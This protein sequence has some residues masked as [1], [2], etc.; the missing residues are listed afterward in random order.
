MARVKVD[1]PD[2]YAFSLEITVRIS[3]VNYGG[4]LSN[5]AVLA[6]IHEA[7][8]QFLHSMDYTEK[9]I[10]DLGIIMADAVIEYKSQG[11]HGDVI[12]IRVGAENFSKYG[13]DFFYRLINQ[14]SGRDVARA[15]TGIVFFDYSRGK[16][17]K[18]PATFRTKIES[19]K[20]A[21]F[22]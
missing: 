17:A 13:C 3:D 5:D 4:H 9:D 15:K 18:R 1:L 7:R 14:N 6:M 19:A 22:Q 11:Y 16:M 10:E 20:L 12:E 8:L 2:A 21:A